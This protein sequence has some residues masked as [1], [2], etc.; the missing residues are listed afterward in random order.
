MATAT[1]R[2]RHTAADRWAAWT[3]EERWTVGA[4]DLEGHPTI[5]DDESGA[6]AAYRAGEAR[7]AAY[8]AEVERLASEPA[9][10]A[11]AD[12]GP[13]DGE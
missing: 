4:G 7:R 12:G 1:T 9:A 6:E 5:D 8:D 13:D 3:D 2:R 10:E 11:G